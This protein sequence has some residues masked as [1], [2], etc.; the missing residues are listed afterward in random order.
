MILT[1][2]NVINRIGGDRPRQRKISDLMYLMIHRFGSH[3]LQWYDDQGITP[4][5][6]G[7]AKFYHDNGDAS[8]ATGGEMPYTFVVGVYGTIWQARHILDVTPHGKRFNVPAIGI[9]CLGDF[10]LLPPTLNQIQAL[11]DLLAGI[12]RLW[13]H[14]EIVGHSDLKWAATPGKQCP[15]SNMPLGKII[16]NVNTINEARAGQ[17]L[18]NAGVSI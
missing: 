4:D 11:E 15:G 1:V 16:E 12:K 13:P 6:L 10:R 17:A 9:A 14:L 7:V 2:E 8:A 18:I 5:A 3:D